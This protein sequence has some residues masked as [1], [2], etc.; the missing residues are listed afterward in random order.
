MPKKTELPKKSKSKAARQAKEAEKKAQEAKRKA[1]IAA[2]NEST[3]KK[4]S[5]LMKEI[6]ERGGK[7]RDASYR[8][9]GQGEG[10]MGRPETKFDYL[11]KRK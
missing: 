3:N 9:L 4:S 6:S 5:N 10:F 8:M 7:A 2:G 1:L 11:K